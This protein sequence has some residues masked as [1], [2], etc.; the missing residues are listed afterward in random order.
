MKTNNQ[1]AQHIPLNDRSQLKVGSKRMSLGV[2]IVTQQV[3]NPTIIH[4][5]GVSIPGLTQWVK[6]MAWLQAAAKVTDAAQI[7]HCCG[8]GVGWKLQL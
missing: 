2:A 4:E 3:K 7:Q 1:R 5:D 8:C 6:D